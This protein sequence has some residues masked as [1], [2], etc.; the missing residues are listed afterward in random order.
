MSFRSLSIAAC[1]CFLLVSVAL[2][3]VPKMINYQGMITHMGEPLTDSIP[4]YFAIYADSVDGDALWGET[5]SSV[6]VQDGLL[7][8]LLGSVNP[9][10]DSVFSGDVRY[11]GMMPKNHPEMTP[12]MKIVSI[13]YAVRSTQA[14]ISLFARNTIIPLPHLN[15]YSSS[16]NSWR[17]VPLSW[18]LIDLDYF[19]GPV[20]VGLQALVKENTW[21]RLINLSTSEGLQNTEVKA[22][23]RGDALLSSEFATVSQTS[24]IAVQIC[25]YAYR[26]PGI[27]TVKILVR[28]MN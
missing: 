5:H 22:T 26:T 15:G 2:A 18:I 16:G 27:Y 8:V 17:T 13:P 11:L 24:I 23:A 1:L 9:I 7:N 19:G 14:D 10:P 12:R 25:N 4:I 28:R 20:E 3:E 21:L 6:V